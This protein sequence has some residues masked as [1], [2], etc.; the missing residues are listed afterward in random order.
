MKQK[1]IKLRIVGAEND[2]IIE[3]IGVRPE[4]IVSSVELL[5]DTKVLEISIVDFDNPQ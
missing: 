1:A 2:V 3:K 4:T 5:D